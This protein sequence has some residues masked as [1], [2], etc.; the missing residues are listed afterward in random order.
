MEGGGAK[1]LCARSGLGCGGG[2]KHNSDGMRSEWELTTKN[3]GHLLYNESG[4][5][6]LK[7]GKYLNSWKVQRTEPRAVLAAVICPLGAFIVKSSKSKT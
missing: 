2:E 5:K 1:K 7:E 3:F 4:Q 6:S